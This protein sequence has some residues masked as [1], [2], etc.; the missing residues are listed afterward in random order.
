MR[1]PVFS[2]TLQLGIV[3]RDLDA[4]MGRYVGGP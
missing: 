4:T 3:M 1:E 2:E